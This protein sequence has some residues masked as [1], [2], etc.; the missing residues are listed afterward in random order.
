MKRTEGHS[1]DFFVKR[2]CGKPACA[3]VV[4]TLWPL[5]KSDG[6]DE[7]GKMI[8]RAVWLCSKHHRLWARYLQRL[9]DERDDCGGDCQ[10]LTSLPN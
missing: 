4:W 8:P 2:R 1:C 3:K 6:F 10:N 5:V 9:S 7:E